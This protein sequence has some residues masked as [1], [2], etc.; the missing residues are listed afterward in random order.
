M[1]MTVTDLTGLRFGYLTVL[2]RHGSTQTKAKR[3]TWLVKCD[4]GKQFVAIGVNMR[5]KSRPGVKSC[6]CK[7]GETLIEQRGSHGMSRT[8]QY[9]S[10]RN[11]RLRCNDPKDKD[12]PNYGARG[13][14][15]CQRWD[16]SFPAFWEDMGATYRENASIE[17][18]DNNGHY[19]PENCRWRLMT[20][21]SNNKRTS[22]YINTPMGRMTI[23]QASR[24]YRSEGCDNTPTDTSSG[25][26]ESDLLLPPGSKRSMI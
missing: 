19:T 15:V 1:V 13:I 14:R 5:N 23:A 2:S 22:H 9:V 3:A 6:G 12:Y 11:M 8:R 7:R 4:C 20:R 21:Q 18:L 16:E 17:R 26:N 25:W 10:W 24:R